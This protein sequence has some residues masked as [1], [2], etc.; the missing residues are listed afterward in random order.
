MLAKGRSSIC[1]RRIA[2]GAAASN[3]DRQATVESARAVCDGHGLLSRR[4]RYFVDRVA[5]ES[6][7]TRVRT[8]PRL[9]AGQQPCDSMSRGSCGRCPGMYPVRTS[10]RCCSSPSSVRRKCAHDRGAIRERRQLSRHSGRDRA[11]AVAE[12]RLNGQRAAPGIP[13]LDSEA[14]PVFRTRRG[15]EQRP[16]VMSRGIWTDFGP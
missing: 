6:A 1:T 5:N 4:S 9:A 12:P 2:A 13:S 16:H 11:S 3:G 7:T 15:C 10:T 8:R 14:T